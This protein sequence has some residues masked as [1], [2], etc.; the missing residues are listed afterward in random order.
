MG[1]WWGGV[2]G[3]QLNGHMATWRAAR[4]A[5]GRSL[6]AGAGGGREDNYTLTGTR[7]PSVA[8]TEITNLTLSPHQRVVCQTHTHTQYLS[9]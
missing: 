4:G 5:W 7:K 1:W 6:M 8:E 2:R 3:G 9:F